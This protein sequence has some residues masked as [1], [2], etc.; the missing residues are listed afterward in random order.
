MLFRSGN[1]I[2]TDASGNIVVTGSSNSSGWVSGGWDVNHNGDTDAFTAKFSPDGDHLWSTYLGGAASDEGRG[3]AMDSSG[4]VLVMGHA[5]STGWVLGGWDTSHNGGNDTFIVKLD[6][7][8]DHLWSTFLGGAGTEQGSGVVVDDFDNVLLAG[9]TNSAGWVS[10]G[11]DTSYD[12][13]SS[14]SFVVKLSPEGEHL[15]ST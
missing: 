10:G 6:S 11:W 2:A 13:G 15:W 12:A 3:I 7:K 5:F 8:G 4:N 9:Y 14:N 1:A